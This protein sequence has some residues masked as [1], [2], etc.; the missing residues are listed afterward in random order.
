MVD[1]ASDYTPDADPAKQ[2]VEV[3]PRLSYAISSTPS[4]R[5]NTLASSSPRFQ[6]VPLHGQLEVSPTAFRIA[7]RIAEL[8]SSKKASN[9][10]PSRPGGCGLVVD[11]GSDGAATDSFRVSHLRC[12]FRCAS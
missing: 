2:A 8:L 11:Y 6:Q 10:A 4:L 9:D 3:F 5:A 7:R 12:K 1:S